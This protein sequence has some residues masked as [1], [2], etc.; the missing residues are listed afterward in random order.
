MSDAAIYISGDMLG[1][2]LALVA[3]SIVAICSIVARAMWPR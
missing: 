1:A 3:V 2:G